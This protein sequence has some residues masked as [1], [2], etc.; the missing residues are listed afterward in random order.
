[1]PRDFVKD[2]LDAFSKIGREID[3]K[4]G[5]H[6]FRFSLADRLLRE[7]LGWGR[8]KGEGHF[9]TREL[10]DILLFDDSNRCVAIIETKNPKFG[11]KDADQAELKRH[12]DDHKTA[13]YG[14]LTNGHEFHLFEYTSAGELNELVPI[15]LDDFLE[16]G[17][18]GLSK[19]ER[20]KVHLLRQLEKERFVGIADSEYFRKT[21]QTIKVDDPKKFPLFIDDLRI[22]L[23]DLTE[24]MDRFF[25]FYWGASSDHYGGK[26]LREEAFPRWKGA[27]TG[28]EEE[29][30]E[31]FCRETAYVILNR[32]LFTRILEDKGILITR[33]ISGKEFA[34]SL[35]MF[36]EGAYETVLK[37][38]YKNVEKFYEHFY[39]FGIFDWWRLPE[40]KRGMLS[41]E[42]KKVQKEI[43]DEFNGVIIHTVEGEK[44]PLPDHA[45]TSVTETTKISNSE[46]TPT[47]NF[48]HTL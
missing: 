21:L 42:E 44:L 10:E 27:S 40:E 17:A 3:E 4:G 15:N 22:L 39:E 11:L 31:K 45:E 7:V 18:E 38:A 9:V 20:Q 23:N 43:E 36:G 37:Q 30:R 28:E 26:F 41:E 6:D 16:K 5:E 34:Q 32:I 48:F 35:T 1:M 12:L 24:N 47:T 46:N 25:K 33:M 19:A 29:L 14:V 8:K 13:Q 2:V